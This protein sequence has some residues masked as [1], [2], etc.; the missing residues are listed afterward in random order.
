MRSICHAEVNPAISGIFEAPQVLSCLYHRATDAYANPKAWQLRSS[1]EIMARK[2]M[3]IL[4]ILVNRE[5]EDIF[6]INEIL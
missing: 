6:Y 2:D 4:D 1:T 5:K 3:N